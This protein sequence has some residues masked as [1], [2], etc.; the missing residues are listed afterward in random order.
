M[1]PDEGR[2]SALASKARYKIV[3]SAGL[4][5]MLVTRPE[6]FSVA[7]SNVAAASNRNSFIPSQGLPRPPYS[8]IP[9]S[10]PSTGSNFDL[11][12]T[13]RTLLPRPRP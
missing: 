5:A 1:P 6:M 2:S 9:S 10:S 11:R 7:V 13:S 8:P 3:G 12:R 4:Y